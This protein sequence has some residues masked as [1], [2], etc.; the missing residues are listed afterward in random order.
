MNDLEWMVLHG[1]FYCVKGS[2]VDVHELASMVMAVNDIWQ[3]AHI[4]F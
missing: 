3:Q 1:E 2:C 4:R